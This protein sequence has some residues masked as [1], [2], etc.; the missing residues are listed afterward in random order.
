MDKGKGVGKGKDRKEQANIGVKSLRKEAR[1]SEPNIEH[2]NPYSEVNNQ[3]ASA[4]TVANNA[5]VQASGM[6]DPG[7]PQQGSQVSQ[8][9]CIK[10]MGTFTHKTCV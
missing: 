1:K 7:Q 4:G 9:R 10:Y 3:A 8:R 5:G 6:A 2:K